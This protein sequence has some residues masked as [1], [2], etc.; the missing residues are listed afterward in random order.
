M[1]DKMSSEQAISH[2]FWSGFNMGRESKTSE[3]S[4]ISENDFFDELIMLRENIAR[5]IELC[6]QT[7][8]DDFGDLLIYVDKAA[9]IARGN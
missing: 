7:V 6:D 1:L 8:R 2:A 3:D 4:S 9:S 5:T